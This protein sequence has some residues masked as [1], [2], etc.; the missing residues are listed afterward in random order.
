MTPSPAGR[1]RSIPKSCERWTAK[2]SVSWKE[3]R[4]TSS[5]TRS[6]AV[7]LPFSCCLRTVALRDP[8]SRAPRRLRSSSMRSST[9]R[10]EGW[11]GC[12]SVLAMTLRSLAERPSGSG[13]VVRAREARSDVDASAG[14][15]VTAVIAVEESLVDEVASEG[16]VVVGEA[17]DDRVHG[18]LV[19]VHAGLEL[20]RDPPEHDTS[21]RLLRGHLGQAA[22]AEE[23]SEHGL[24]VLARRTERESRVPRRPD[25]LGGPAKGLG[26]EPI[27]PPVV[28]Q[29][30]DARGDE[31]VQVLAQPWEWDVEG[32]RELGRRRVRTGEVSRDREPIG[33]GKGSEDVVGGLGHVG[34][35]SYSRRRAG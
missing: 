26:I 27:G 8:S 32:V 17:S 7:S 4:S 30:D 25:L 6:R 24:L 9:V 13:R 31:P 10:T 20:E 1:L 28:L 18:R 21:L 15:P 14:T 34:A 19:V 33:F 35:S 12:S 16:S 11:G 29:A 2:G 5:S 22:V 3:S 23:R